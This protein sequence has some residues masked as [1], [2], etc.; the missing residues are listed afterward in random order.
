VVELLA[1]APDGLTVKEIADRLGRSISEIFRMIMVMEQRRWLSKDPGNDR[2]RVTYKVLDLA[3]RATPTQELAQVA[4]PVMYSLVHRTLQSCHIV[5]RYGTR[6]LVVLRQENPGSTGLSVRLGTPVDLIASSSGHALLAFSE[7]P[8]LERTLAEIA[9]PKGTRLDAV[10]ATVA[11]VRARG[12]ETMESARI[13]GVRDVSY[14][15]FG[16]DG[17]VVAALTVPF[18]TVIDG[19]ET[20]DFEAVRELVAAGA[21]DISQG[22]GYRRL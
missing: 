13:A 8:E 16:F 21:G 11:R 22:L 10:R 15:I 5:V 20:M 12:Y 7:E 6:A 4:T 2:Y 19:S 17:R 3:F 14:P 18:L 1:T 9:L